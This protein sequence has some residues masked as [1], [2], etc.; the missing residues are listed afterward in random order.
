VGITSWLC[1]EEAPS[2]QQQI[3]TYPREVIRPP[4]NCIGAALILSNKEQS[5]SE[6]FCYGT[7]GRFSLYFFGFCLKS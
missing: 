1:V 5:F 6:Y 2:F 7:L 4:S 3:S